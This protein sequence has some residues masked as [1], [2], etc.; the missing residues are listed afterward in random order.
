MSSY[1]ASFSG[2]G[3]LLR[4]EFIGAALYTKAQAVRGMAEATA[5]YEPSSTTHFRDAFHVKPPEVADGGDR[6]SVTVYNDDDAAVQIEL[7]T[8][9]T[10]AHRTLTRALDA[11]GD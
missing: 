5:P 6:V 3:E 1:N 4:A 7:G 8:S 10:P 11:V 2:I 9:S